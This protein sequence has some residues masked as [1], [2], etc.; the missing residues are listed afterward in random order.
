ML[1][2]LLRCQKWIEKSLANRHLGGGM[3]I[4]YDV[5]SRSVERRDCPG[6]G[7]GLCRQYSGSA[8]ILFEDDDREDARTQRTSPV[9]P[10]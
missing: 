9:E 10:A 7:G 2:W 8:L 1:G 5:T 3:L 6:R 4:L